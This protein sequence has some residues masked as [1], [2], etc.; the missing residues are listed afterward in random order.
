MEQK[1]QKML[2]NAREGVAGGFCH[3]RGDERAEGML[4]P[5]VC[6][7]N[8]LVP[9]VGMMCGVIQTAAA[10]LAKAPREGAAQE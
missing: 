4:S 3:T 7:S 6:G 1:K 8:Q 9:V 2:G 10:V 5:G